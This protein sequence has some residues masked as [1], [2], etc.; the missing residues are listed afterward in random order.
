MGAAAAA[1]ACRR[2]RLSPAEV[3]CAR[4]CGCVPVGVCP[5]VCVGELLGPRTL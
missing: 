4:G 2:E 1:A 5:W 3:A